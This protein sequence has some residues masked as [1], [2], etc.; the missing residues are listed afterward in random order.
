MDFLR[1]EGGALAG[2]VDA[3][4]LIGF[5]KRLVRKGLEFSAHIED[6]LATGLPVVQFAE[7][8]AEE[9]IGFEIAGG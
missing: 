1:R 2:H 5:G 8:G 3:G 7:F 9:P 4:V 6:F